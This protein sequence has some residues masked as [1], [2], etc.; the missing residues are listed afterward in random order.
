[1]RAPDLFLP[2]DEQLEVDRQ[3]AVSGQHPPGRFDLIEG[4]ALVVNG[5]AGPALAVDDHRIERWRGPF[6][7]RID[8]LHVVMAIDDHR[9]R[10]GAGVQ[11][12]GV[13][14]R[15]AAGLQDGHVLQTGLA[16]EVGAEFGGRPNV[17]GALWIGRDR[18]NSQPGEKGRQDAVPLLFGVARQRQIGHR[19]A[20][21]CTGVTGMVAGH[22]GAPARP[23]LRAGGG[24]GHGA[25]GG[26]RGQQPAPVESLG[27][28]DPG[29]EHAG[30]GR[31][32]RDCA[33][34]D[35]RARAGRGGTDGEVVRVPR[36]SRAV[37]LPVRH[38]QCSSRSGPPRWSPNRYGDRP[39]SGDRAEDRL[40]AGEP[41]GSRGLRC[42]LPAG[43]RARDAGHPAGRVR[44]R[45]VRSSR[46]GSHRPHHL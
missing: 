26:L 3:P 44:H 39:A 20:T 4:L 43:H 32:D 1:M 18:R 15:A 17:G 36:G 33:A 45:R 25:G 8:R 28:D 37:G 35:H 46:R 30:R 42:R 31:V 34:G 7:Q 41:R 22:G 2:L 11:P 14:R 29:P 12:I 21:Y 16:T 10:G 5:A 13:D 19:P 38:G 27:P 9:R 24:G 6:L 40:A 23:G